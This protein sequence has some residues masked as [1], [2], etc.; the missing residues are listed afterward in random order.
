MASIIIGSQWGDEGKGKL[1]DILSQEYDVVARCQGGANAG[2]T[3]VVSGKKIA[4][5]L[6][7]SG[8]LNERATCI[9]GNGMV[10][11]LPTFFKEVEGLKEKGIKYDGRLF[12]SDRAHIVFDLHQMID[13]M[14]E[15]ELSAGISNDSIGTTKKGIGPCYSSKASRGGLRVCDLFFPDQFKK[16]FTRLVENKHKRFG[17]FEYDVDAEIK[18]YQEF[19]EKIKPFV[20]DSVYYL[21]KAFKDGKKVLI[22]GA[23]STML[24]LDF[25]TYPY[26][27]S[28]ASSVGGACTGLGIAPNKVI[29]QIG[30][31]KAYTTRVGAG[32]FP[33]ELHGDFGEALRKEG[34]E[35]G[36]T[37]GRPR[38][39]GWLDAVVLRYTSMIN[40]F[41]KL[42][43]TKLDVLSK[44]DEIKIGVQY[45]YNGEIL[46]SFPAS[47]E[48][49]AKCEVVYETLP[50]W[51]SNIS[52]ITKYEDLPIQAQQYIERIEKLIGVP[53]YW[54]GVGQD[55]ASMI[56]HESN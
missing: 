53:V 29:T 49:L 31:V 50:G 44:L 30:V 52:N 55:R 32:P 45:K 19:A 4:L 22:E 24:D 16:A 28:S 20:I 54:I 18:R 9:L 14:K 26:V 35:Y 27:T 21:N 48:V 39:I 47:L 1:V 23:Q 40:D 37:T 8:I 34:G 51:N 12:V 46:D 38:R 36:T 33:T 15:Q 3:I 13:A 43:L 10:I 7:P 6:I 11:H 56:I 17:S 25:G 41:T 5:H 2:H 42:N